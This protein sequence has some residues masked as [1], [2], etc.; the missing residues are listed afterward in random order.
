M[1]KIITLLCFIFVLGTSF[2]QITID[3]D[4][5]DWAAINPLDTGLPPESYGQVPVQT[6]LDF[7]LKHIYMTHDTANV[8]CKID[9]D[10]AANFN[11][12]YNFTN[13]P[14]FEIYFD[15]EI[16]DT[17]GF[18]WGWWTNASN[19]YVNLAPTYI[20]ILLISML[21]YIFIPVEEC[22]HIFLVSLFCWRFCQWVLTVKITSL[23]FQFPVT[24]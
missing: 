1:K 19:Y 11:N 3:G 14:V 4:M 8:Y 20:P 13:P 9:L 2:A 22:R 6:Y 10:D 17:T 23:S 12:F 5:L 18:D 7:N 24:W 21:N 16:G 15:T